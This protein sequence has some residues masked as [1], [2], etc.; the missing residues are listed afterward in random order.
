MPSTFK[1]VLEILLLL[2]FPLG[3]EIISPRFSSSV[4]FTLAVKEK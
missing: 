1:I 4:I 2:F 3:L